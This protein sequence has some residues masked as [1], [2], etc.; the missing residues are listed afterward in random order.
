MSRR[1]DIVNTVT[2]LVSSFL[3]YDRKEDEDLRIGAIQGAIA[4]GEITVDDIVQRFESRLREEL[5]DG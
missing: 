2:D 3:Y 4:D 1:E 5:S